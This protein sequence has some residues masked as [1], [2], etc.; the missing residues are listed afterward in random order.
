MRHCR[1]LRHAAAAVAG[2]AAVAAADEEIDAAPHECDG[3]F[4]IG[5]RESALDNV[6]L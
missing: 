4:E 1:E 3:C 2:A 6:V 5:R